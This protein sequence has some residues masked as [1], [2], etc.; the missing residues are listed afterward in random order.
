ME[1]SEGV[2]AVTGR[3]GS[4]DPVRIVGDAAH[5]LLTGLPGPGLLDTAAA[6]S[7]R[8]APR[9]VILVDLDQFRAVNATHGHPGGDRVLCEVADR[10]REAGRPHQ[11][12]RLGG[13]EFAI[14]V[15]SA[16]RSAC[17]EI[18]ADVREALRA[19]IRLDE[20]ELFLDAG[21]GVAL[22]HGELTGWE[23]L[24]RAN[25]SLRPFKQTGRPPRIVV[26]EEAAHGAILD[27]QALSLD[28]R[29]ALPRNQLLL[30]YQPLVDLATRRAIG[31]EALVR[32]QHP[33][34]GTVAPLR[35]VPLAEQ[36]GLMPDLGEW[37]LRRA[38]ADARGWAERMDD[39][40]F[41]SVNISIRQLE[42]PDFLIRFWR[43]LDRS[44]LDPKLLRVEVTESVLVDG[45]DCITPVLDAIRQMG[46]GVLLDDFGTGYSSLGYL[47]DLPLD[48]VKLD[49]VF[50]R[51][52]TV[53]AEALALAGAVTT[54]LTQ[55]GLEMIAEGLETAAHVAQLRSLGCHIGQGFYFAKPGPVEALQFEGLGRRSRHG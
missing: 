1:N 28:L 35:F 54:L 8:D 51:D 33:V 2:V 3:Y 13:D 55:L 43:V 5:D 30:H 11:V 7:H 40:P 12:A 47:R 42:D 24:S 10:L 48:G 20:S 26:Y 4:T 15:A 19:P 6:S 29:G 50:I 25:A 39:P 22:A 49:R 23:L 38:C 53:S 14:I 21:F 27:T 52:L 16:D 44:G 31:F 34:R 36:R 17:L 41:V 37:V 45:I 32:W 9:S 18:A 46:V